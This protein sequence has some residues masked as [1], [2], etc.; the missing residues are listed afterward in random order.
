M[1]NLALLDT[2]TNRSY[3]DSLFRQKRKIII[4]R[5]SKGLFV[6]VCTKNIFLKVY[7][8]KLDKMDIWGEDDKRDYIKEMDNILNLFF[9]GRFGR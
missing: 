8:K 2:H 6:P 1:G 7:S 4:D 9:D 3:Q 5:E